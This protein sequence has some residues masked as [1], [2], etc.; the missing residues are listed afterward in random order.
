M[1]QFEDYLHK[2]NQAKSV[3][4]LFD[5]F[6]KTLSHHGFDRILFALLN[7]HYDLKL[8]AGI[9]VMQ[10]YPG[11]WMKFYFEKGY[12]K[13]DPIPLYA[14]HQREAFQWA[15]IVKKVELGPKQRKCLN[16]GID[17]GLHHGIGVPL[18]GPSHQLAG[19]SLASSEKKEF[20]LFQ[21][22]LL[23]AYCNHFYIAYRRLHRPH[24]MNPKNIVLTVTERDVLA[25][26]ASGK[27]D[28]EISEIMKVSKHTVN[29]HFRNIYKKLEANN[30]VLAVVKGL[31]YGLVSL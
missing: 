30:R 31:T 8:R 15:E 2:A 13:I 17:A 21:K 6:V 7:D 28:D 1:H 5:I 18:T 4:E 14:I 11:D 23:T 24:P 25:R 22:D 9:G 10:N 27:T 19:I 12:D 3:Q 29:M 20:G 26:A 16:M